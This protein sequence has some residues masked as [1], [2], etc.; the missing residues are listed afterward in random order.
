MKQ[1]F[2]AAFFLLVSVGLF[3][4]YIDPTYGTVKTMQTEN[5]KLSEALDK[6]RQ[7]QEVR[8]SL[9]AKYNTFSPDD[10]GKLEKLL[11]DHIDNIR[12]II[13]LDAIA[14]LHNVAIEGFA[15]DS[16]AGNMQA[17]GVHADSGNSSKANE[18]TFTFSV[19]TNYLTF[20]AFMNDLE[21][22]LRIIDITHLTLGADDADKTNRYDITI[23]TY[24]LN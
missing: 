20:Q 3:F 5:G 16:N 10:L 8:D 15:F 18:V 1:A 21:Q 24:W 19:R 22:S 13:D 2:L 6:S 9:R 23:R 17:A 11:P 12:L 14:K 7:L 4:A